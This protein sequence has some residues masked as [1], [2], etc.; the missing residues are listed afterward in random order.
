MR[1]IT[2]VFTIALFLCLGLGTRVW[3]AATD[4][5][6][7]VYMQ[8]CASC[9]GKEG[10]GNGPVS[11]YL[12]IKVPDL[13]VLQKN[14]KGI[15]PMGKI[16]SAI[17]GSRIVRAHGDREMPVWGEIFRKEAEAAKY[18]ELTSLLKT[19]MIAEYLATLQR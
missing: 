13:T 2:S 12:K 5:G 16:M 17:D 6:Q 9:H 1:L 10:R 7:Q 15:Y 8:Y 3:A 18:T 11:P 4:S 19:K 14:N